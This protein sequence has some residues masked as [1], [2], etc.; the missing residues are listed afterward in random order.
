MQAT[1]ENISNLERRMTVA[2]PIKPIE[3]EIGQRL[4]TLAR[5]AR[6][7]GFRPGKVPLRVVQQQYGQQVRQEVISKKVEETFGQAVEQHA[8]NVAGYPN[9][10]PKPLADN[11]ESYEYIATFEIFPEVVIGDLSGIEIER[12]QLEVGDAEVDKTLEV[13]R[14]QRAVFEPADRGAALG[15]SV[16]IAFSSTI[17]NQKVEDTQ[18]QTI[19]IVLGEQGRLE[20]FDNALLEAKAGETRDF[21]LTFPVD[22]QNAALSGKTASYSVNVVSVSVPKLPE[23]NADFAR[24][25]GVEDG[26]VAKMREEVKQ[27]L[28]QEVTKRIRLVVKSQVMAGLVNT[29]NLELPKA[30]L[31]M[32]TGRQMEA[33]QQTLKERGVDLT[34]VNLQPEMFAEQAERSVKLRL[35]L[36]ELVRSNN[37]Q[38]TAEQIRATIEEHAQSFEDQAEVLDWYYADAERLNEPG[39][40]A[41]EENVVAWVLEKAKVTEK[42]T[43]FDELMSK[44]QA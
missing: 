34:Q 44:G 13:L 17:D 29:V 5:T 14:R 18:G 20:G 38:A 41:T 15:D 4:N 40:Q 23:I 3:D 42:P 25:L 24:E 43:T 30:L 19:A 7:P 39:A 27:S 10:E 36:I 28:A 22:Y 11:S 1:V 33:A 31:A 12:P 8:L 6:M 35:I 9:I 21:D 2:M 32:E 26:D 16:A 37:L